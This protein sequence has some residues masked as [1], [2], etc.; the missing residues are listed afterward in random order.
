VVIPPLF[1]HYSFQQ[2]VRASTEGEVEGDSRMTLETGGWANILT[3][4]SFFCVS[5]FSL[6]SFFFFNFSP[7]S[8]LVSVAPRYYGKGM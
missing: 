7:F 6:V 1:C 8:F 3:F 5:P 4:S 2:P